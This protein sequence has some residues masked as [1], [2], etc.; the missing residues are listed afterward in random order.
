MPTE[1]TAENAMTA[2][3][4]RAWWRTRRT[5]AA[6]V[7]LIGLDPTRMLVCRETPAVRAPD[8]A[9]AVS[10]DQVPAR[11]PGGKW[12]DRRLEPGKVSQMTE[13]KGAGPRPRLAK[14]LCC[15]VGAARDCGA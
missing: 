5:G 12:E 7:M 3:A 9:D 8:G 14:P 4:S 10:P 15:C 13:I 11:S 2:A 1:V 6:G